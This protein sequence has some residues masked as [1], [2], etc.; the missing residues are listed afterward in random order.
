MARDRIRYDRNEAYDQLVNEH[1]V[2]NSYVDFFVFCAAL[3]FSRDERRPNA[4]EGA[5]HELLWMHIEG[6]ELFEAVSKAIAYQDTGNPDALDDKETQLE[7]LA[8]YAAAGAE[9]VADEVLTAG[10]D[11]VPTVVR[12]ILNEAPPLESGTE[13]DL[14]GL[15]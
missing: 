8:E 6:T 9:I 7:L 10:D 4:Y 3:G 14:S 13:S 12:F 5:D 1:E 15:L 2:F 11:I